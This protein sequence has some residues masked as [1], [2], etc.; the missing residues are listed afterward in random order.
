MY[1]HKPES[2]CTSISP[3]NRSLISSTVND[4]HSS[5]KPL[6]I[7]AVGVMVHVLVGPGGRGWGWGRWWGWGEVVGLG[8][9][10]GTGGRWWDWVYRGGAGGED[11][12]RVSNTDNLSSDGGDVTFK[13]T[14]KSYPADGLS[15]T[16]VGTISV[17]GDRTD[18]YQA[19]CQL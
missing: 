3:V 11:I 16:Q 7:E 1:L 5:D 2:L 19:G 8:G 6:V 10:G 9:G 4:K 15:L 17:E 14:V 13:H 12:G 18:Q